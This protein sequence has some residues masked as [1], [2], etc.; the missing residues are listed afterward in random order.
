MTTMLRRAGAMAGATA[1]L[2]MYLP[3]LPAF[4]VSGVTAAY[5]WQGNA[6]GAAPQVPAGGLYVSASPAGAQ[7]VS[8]LRFTLADGESAPVVTLQVAQLE[9]A[10][11]AAATGLN[12]TPILACPTKGAWQEP[13]GGH[14]DLSS[15]PAA[16]CSHGS[17]SGVL[18]ADQKTMKFDLSLLDLGNTVDIEMLPGQ[19]NPPASG[20]VPGAP[21]QV[22][23]AFDA[24]FAKVTE[25]QI[26]VTQGATGGTPVGGDT[27]GAVAPAPAS[28]DGVPRMPSAAFTPPL[29]SSPGLD[30]S[31]VV[32]PATATDS[33]STGVAPQVADGSQA[34]RPV[35][36]QTTRWDLGRIILILLVAN[37]VI[38]IWWDGNRRA[39]EGGRPRRNLFDPPPPREPEAT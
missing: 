2:A 32:A 7:A 29:A 36:V 4:A 26:D 3:A 28:G 9:S 13:A 8:T 5:W 11:A 14:G 6:T 38:Y 31:P 19:V 22:Y 23:P 1:A 12:A 16:D 18:S 37:M 10:G 15:A 35:A 24:A 39:T 25:S 34:L 27:G 21:S 17:V 33:G 20:T 30:Q